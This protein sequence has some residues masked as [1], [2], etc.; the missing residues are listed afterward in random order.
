MAK[1]QG[2]YV[3]LGK[4]RQNPGSYIK[5][6]RRPVYTTRVL[7]PSS[8]AV[9]PATDSLASGL[10]PHQPSTTCL[11][12]DRVQAHRQG[13]GIL[14]SQSPSMKVRKHGIPTT[15]YRS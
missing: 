3:L 12:S 11:A 15:A 7:N 10:A 5:I 1:G 2:D 4:T 13:D 8:C 6:I 9:S 14:G